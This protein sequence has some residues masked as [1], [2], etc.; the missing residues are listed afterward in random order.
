MNS[1]KLLALALAATPVLSLADPTLDRIMQTKE[2]RL[3]HWTDDEPFSFVEAGQPTGYAVELCKRFLQDLSKKA[4]GE[5]RIKWV[6][7]DSKTRFS[8]LDGGQY[9]ILCGGTT[10][11]AERQQK[12]A[13]SHT[14]F[15]TGTRV[16]GRKDRKLTSLAAYKG[17]RLGVMP[18]TTA[19]KLI[20]QLSNEK[21]YNYV[22]VPGKTADELWTLLEQGKVDGLA[23]DDTQ[24][25]DHAA[26]SKA[27]PDAYAFAHEYLSVQ[28]YGL[29]LRK[30]DPDL[31]KALNRTLSDIMIGGEAT[32]IY[33]RWFMNA[34]RKTPLNH[35]LRE[36]FNTP[37]NHPAFP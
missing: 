34:K 35:I 29:L 30:S 33:N 16:M 13:F 11:T 7:L 4:G 8:L 32:G 12:Y 6:P 1:L 19:T 23:Y 18:G 15:V 22:F 10:N 3:G 37:N 31:L 14:I 9:D 25:L 28:P 17:L 2:I 27:G 26:H 24:L 36:D 21:H 5:I 20:T